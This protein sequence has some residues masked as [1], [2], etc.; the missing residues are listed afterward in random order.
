LGYPEDARS[1]SGFDSFLP[2]QLRDS[3]GLD[4]LLNVAPDFVV[5]GILSRH[6]GCQVKWQSGG[7]FVLAFNC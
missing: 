3:A 4:G 6:A 1:G 2:S 7:V 5:A